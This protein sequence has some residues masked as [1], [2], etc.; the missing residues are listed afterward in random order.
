MAGLVRKLRDSGYTGMI[1]PEYL[2][3][4]APGDDLEARAVAFL[5]KTL[6]E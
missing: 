5:R 6:D 2:G 1:C 4:A 3:K